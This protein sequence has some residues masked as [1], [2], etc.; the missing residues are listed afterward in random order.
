MAVKSVCV[1]LCDLLPHE[2]SYGDKMAA[3]V[4]NG[5][6][7]AFELY[8]YGMKSNDVCTASTSSIS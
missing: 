6:L 5:K 8:L 4:T 7:L 3:K 1:H 2:I